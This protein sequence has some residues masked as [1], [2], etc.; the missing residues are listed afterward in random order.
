MNRD[1]AVL[2]IFGAL[3]LIIGISLKLFI[4]R[5]V[6]YRRNSSGAEGFKNYRNALLTPFLG[7]HISIYRGTAYYPW[8]ISARICQVDAIN[9]L[10]LFDKVHNI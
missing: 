8:S 3:A 4:G 7:E 10:I 6:F 5:R 1:N 9:Y 2:I